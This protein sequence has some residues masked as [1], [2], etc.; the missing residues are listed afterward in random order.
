MN[1]ERLYR[2]G[3]KI[4]GI[5]KA[6]FVKTFK[7]Y[8]QWCCPE[9]TDKKNSWRTIFMAMKIISKCTAKLKHDLFELAKESWQS[10]KTGKRGY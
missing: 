4:N 10:R 8:G 5:Q 7:F 9:T 6:I 1:I 2:T 3:S